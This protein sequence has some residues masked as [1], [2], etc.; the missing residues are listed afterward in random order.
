[1]HIIYRLKGALTTSQ[2]QE[3]RL[4]R[5]KIRKD[6]FINL[7]DVLNEIYESEQ[8][9]SIKDG[10]AHFEALYDKSLE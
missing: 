7:K 4:Q 6:I 1:M 10:E 2:I 5:Q 3:L 8:K 9:L